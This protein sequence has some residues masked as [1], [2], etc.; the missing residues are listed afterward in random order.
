[1][2]V[3]TVFITGANGGFGAA[4]AQKFAHNGWQLILQVRTKDKA[5]ALISGLPDTT[6]YH[7]FICDLTDRA[8][9]DKCLAHIPENF[10]N[11]DTLVNNAGLALGLDPAQTC[12]MHDWDTMVDVNIKALTYMT[13]QILPNM[14]ERQSGHIIN[15]GSTAGNYPY[16]GGNVY[17][18]TKAFV[19]QFS[20]CLRADL[21]GTHV[22]VTN[23]EPGIAET[24]FSRTRFKNNNDKADA[25][26]DGTKALQ[27]NDVANA[28][29]WATSC[30][31]HMNINRM[32]IMPT[33]QSFAPHPIVRDAD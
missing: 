10:K 22:R 24:N 18:A 7:L 26:Y 20:L 23:M 1:M 5:D 30:P 32:E 29:F 6:K 25:V 27:A 8:A 2:T 21:H 11:I 3:K 33:V 31:P 19:K 13:R 14:I 28:V 9:I 12:D 17:C 4:M 15:I 16:P